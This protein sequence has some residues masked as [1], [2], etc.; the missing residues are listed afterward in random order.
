MELV[1]AEKVTRVM[2]VPTML[3]QIID[4][5]E[6]EKYS[7]SSLKI[8]TYGA[9]PMP[10][11]VIKKAMALFPGVSF[12]NAFGQTETA[13]TITVLGPEDH[14][15]EGSDSEKEKKL[16]RLSSIGKPLPGIEMRVIDKKGKDLPIGKIGEIVARG[17][18]IM[19]Q[20]WKGEK[21]TGEIMDND[22]WVHT[23][24]VGYMD[25]E[26]YFFL[27]GRAKDI[28]IRG[29]ENI[30]PAEVEDVLSACP[31]IEDVAVVGIP[32][33]EWGQQPLAIVVLK[34][35]E[36]AATEEIIEYC[37][38][39]I[40]SYKRPRGVVFIKELPRNSMGKVLKRELRDKYG[41]FFSSMKT[42]NG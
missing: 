2:M 30:S 12:I 18:R 3:K 32:D 9:A 33:E 34:S 21:I 31:K 5:P 19:A 23:G 40:A 27:S 14:V 10:V 42:S 24:D 8:I 22:G 28:I 17:P 41:N 29:G 15:I 38:T 39:R 4:H 16:K 35:G 6:F 11:Q 25:E 1:D 37:R 13:S 20:Y 7:L 26:G 36:S